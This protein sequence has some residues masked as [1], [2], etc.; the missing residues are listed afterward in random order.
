MAAKKLSTE[1]V[2][3]CLHLAVAILLTVSCA[4]AAAAP[5]GNNSDSCAVEFQRKFQEFIS[6]KKTCKYA[7]YRDCCQ[8]RVFI[9]SVLYPQKMFY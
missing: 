1:T 6:L 4:M 9:Q 7:Y 2:L 8:V 3:P 5:T